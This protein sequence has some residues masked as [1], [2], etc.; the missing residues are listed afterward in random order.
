ME[1]H[2]FNL[3]KIKDLTSPVDTLQANLF[4][5]TEI[6]NKDEHY[7]QSIVQ[8]FPDKD[9][10]L[11]INTLTNLINRVKIKLENIS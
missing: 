5:L 9:F 11:Q 8:Q 1:K 7:T 4:Q 3:E 10:N 6:S 2:L